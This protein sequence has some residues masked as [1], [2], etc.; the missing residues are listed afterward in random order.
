MGIFLLSPFLAQ[1]QEQESFKYEAFLVQSREFLAKK[2]FLRAANIANHAIQLNPYRP[3]AYY[4]ASLAYYYKDELVLSRKMILEALKRAKDAQKRAFFQRVY[5]KIEEKGQYFQL[6]REGRRA[7]EK[8]YT[9]FGAE[10][11][12]EAWKLRPAD[13]GLALEVVELFLKLEEQERAWKVLSSISP[14]ALDKKQKGRYDGFYQRLKSTFEALYQQAMQRG[15]KAFL[16]KKYS[17][18][19]ALFRRAHFCSPSSILPHLWLA[20]T[21][22]QKK[23][24]AKSLSQL[25]KMVQKGYWKERHQLLFDPY[26]APLRAQ[27]SFRKFVHHTFGWLYPPQVIR[28]LSPKRLSPLHLPPPKGT[29]ALPP[30]QTRVEKIRYKPLLQKK[31]LTLTGHSSWV[32]SVAFSP[33]G[34][35]LASASADNTIKLWEVASRRSIAT[36][37]GHRNWVRSVAFS[38]DG[39]LLASASDDDTVKVWKVASWQ[40][41]ATLTEHGA[42]VYSVAFS[43]DGKL[44]A[45][46]SKDNT[47]KVWKVGSWQCIATLTGH[48]DYVRSV[49]FSPDGKLLAS[50]SKDQTIKVWFLSFSEVFFVGGRLPALSLFGF[51]KRHLFA[52]YGWDGLLHFF[53]T[54]RGIWLA[55]YRLPSPRSLLLSHSWLYAQDSR[56][57]YYLA[58]SPRSPLLAR[59]R[60]GPLT[61]PPFP[62]LQVKFLDSQRLQAGEP[63]RLQIEVDNRKGK[64]ALEQ[65]LL[66]LSSPEHPEYNRLLLVGRVEGGSSQKVLLSLPTSAQWKPQRVSLLLRSTEANGYCAPVVKKEF[67][68]ER[69]TFPKFLITCRIWEG[70]KGRGIGNGD[71]ILQKGES[72]LLEV[73]VLNVGKSSGHGKVVLSSLPPGVRIF[74]SPQQ[75]FSTI[76]RGQIHVFTYQLSILP[77]YAKKT[78]PL[79]L[80]VEDKTVELKVQKT[81]E[82]PMDTSLSPTGCILSLSGKTRRQ[83]ALLAKPSSSAQVLQEIPAG[84]QL[85]IQGWWGPFFYASLSQGKGGWIP[86]E[87]IEVEQWFKADSP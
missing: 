23:E 13:F 64:G 50:G 51:P 21:Y 46:G 33:D 11:L 36:L 28:P 25:E 83:I 27:D 85:K 54:Q 58:P 67:F 82:F 37:T 16:Q 62:Q 78:L 7:L 49:A 34:K 52:A 30:S 44:L 17:Q 77:E 10:K 4:Y 61:A 43:P 76:G 9:A 32:G 70:Q 79:T 87:A 24:W 39:K 1:G 14:A 71:N 80:A 22:A 20:R 60:R 6:L 81:L 3:E 56:G 65:F 74:G 75:R 86:A 12:Y 19:E 73:F 2:Y 8:G 42:D 48:G 40:C 69:A 41:I 72:P 31:V 55:S 29:K 84:A 47:V 15:K 45:S 57:R 66:Y 53:D 26:L 35:L 68:I 59:F 5:Q 63:V 18:A 38:P